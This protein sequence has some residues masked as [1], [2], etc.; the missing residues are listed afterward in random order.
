MR[1]YPGTYTNRMSIMY[2]KKIEL[3]SVK[4][5]Q[6][7]F[8]SHRAWDFVMFCFGTCILA[9]VYYFSVQ[10]RSSDLPQNFRSRNSLKHSRN[11]STHD[12]MGNSVLWW[13]QPNY[14]VLAFKRL[15]ATL[16]NNVQ[17][18]SRYQ[19]SF[20][21]LQDNLSTMWLFVYCIANY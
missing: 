6:A 11:I 10:S 2:L 3:T 1:L 9:S 21:R 15:H 4:T 5:L 20:L 12:G 7:G 19:C 17:E 8:P 16:N 18:W 14:K 13:R